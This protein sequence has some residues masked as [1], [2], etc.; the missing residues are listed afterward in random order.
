MDLFQIVI[1]MYYK[2]YVCK[3]SKLVKITMNT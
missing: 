1:N 3:N 2:I